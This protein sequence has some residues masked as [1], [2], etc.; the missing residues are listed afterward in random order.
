MPPTR[1]ATRPDLPRRKRPDVGSPGESSLAPGC[2]PLAGP[3][4][5]DRRIGP[6]DWRWLRLKPGGG[7]RPP[8]KP[9]LRPTGFDGSGSAGSGG[10]AACEPPPFHQ[11]WI[12]AGV[13]AFSGLW[14]ALWM[15][16]T[17]LAGL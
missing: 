16:G 11:R 4:A 12:V 15:L 1:P 8:R 6:E 10:D 3:P 14:L 13:L 7:N 2:P 9:P 5:D 17:L